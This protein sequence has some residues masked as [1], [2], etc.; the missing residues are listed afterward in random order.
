MTLV[1]IVKLS[2]VARKTNVDIKKI[3]I[4]ALKTYKIVII[5]LMVQNKLQSSIFWGNFLLANT[6]MKVVLKILF[7]FSLLQT[8]NLHKKSLPRKVT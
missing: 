6:S 2:F 3:D 7:L 4:S 1:Y 8:F 5:D